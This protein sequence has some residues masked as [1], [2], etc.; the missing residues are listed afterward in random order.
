MNRTLHT[1]VFIVAAITLAEALYIIGTA[2]TWQGSAAATAGALIA[3]GAL[4]WL[5]ARWPDRRP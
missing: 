3:V 5:C 4:V 1:V 2:H